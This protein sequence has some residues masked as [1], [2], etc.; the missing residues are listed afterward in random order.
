MTSPT[1]SATPTH[2]P[3]AP[4]AIFPLAT[5]T[6]TPASSSILELNSWSTS[7]GHPTIGTPA[8]RLSST[9][10]HPQWL[11]N[12]PVDGCDSISRWGAHPWT[13]NPR[14]SP[15]LIRSSNPSGSHSSLN[16]SAASNPRG[17]LMAQTKGLPLASSPAARSVIWEGR[18]EFWE[19]NE[20]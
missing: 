16:P 12:A 5:S 19:P 17:G 7:R 11:R 15:H 18:I 9:E 8:L 20:T 4:S 2:P 3:L 14:P 1:A 6:H 13:R 10:F